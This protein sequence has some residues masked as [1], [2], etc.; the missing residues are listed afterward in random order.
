MKRPVR[1]IGTAEILASGEAI[2][3]KQILVAMLYM[4]LGL[5]VS[6]HVVLHSKDLFTS[7]SMK[8]HSVDKSLRERTIIA[9]DSISNA[10][11]SLESSKY[12]ES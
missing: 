11:T 9:F 6:L 1:A 12:H 2:D 7:F 10:A 3:E 4:G 8:R 5:Q